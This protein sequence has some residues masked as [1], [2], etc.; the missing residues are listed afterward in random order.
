MRRIFIVMFLLIISFSDVYGASPFSV[1]DDASIDNNY[2][3]IEIGISNKGNKLN[4]FGSLGVGLNNYFSIG[5]A[6]DIYPLPFNA[7]DIS[8]KLRFVN[9]P[10][11][12]T[13]VAINYGMDNIL[14]INLI[15][16]FDIKYFTF[17][18]NGGMNSDTVNIMNFGVSLQNDKL[19]NEKLNVGIEYYGEKGNDISSN[20]GIGC[21]FTFNNGLCFYGGYK[22]CI[23]DKN[24]FTIVGIV[25]DF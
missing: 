17:Y 18:M 8:G 1:D 20:V 2:R 7:F 6:I 15:Q 9:T 23:T 12:G 16:R 13:A 24:G 5:V 21:S 19:L 14:S 10:L 22:Y 25:F 4:S 11:L 3:E